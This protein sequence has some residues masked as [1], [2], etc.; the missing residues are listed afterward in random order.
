MEKYIKILENIGIMK[1]KDG[2]S[3][4]EAIEYKFAMDN[5]LNELERLQ[6]ENNDLRAIKETIR[7]LE[8]D[9]EKDDLYYVV[10]RGSY[11][12]KVLEN[13]QDFEKT[14]HIS[15]LKYLIDSN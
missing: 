7:Y 3:Y 4:D 11:L 14:V 12:A 13:A 1:L 10:G 8:E 5:V 15:K 2:L 6:K 9:G